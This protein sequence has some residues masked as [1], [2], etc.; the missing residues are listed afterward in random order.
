MEGDRSQLGRAAFLI[1]L[2]FSPTLAIAADWRYLTSGNGGVIV[3]VDTDSIRELPPIQ[4]QRPFPVRQI[5]VKMDY[6]QDK[7]VTYRESRALHR[8]HCDAETS[9]IVSE[10]IYNPNGGVVRSRSE[11]DYDFHYRPITPDTIG[12]AIMEFACGRRS[13]L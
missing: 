1:G 7:S 9:T 2:L 6:S 13:V 12:Y 5:W 4:I 11:E 8:F 3:Q 10:V